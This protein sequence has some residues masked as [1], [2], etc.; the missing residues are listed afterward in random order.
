MKA[1]PL[2]ANPDCPSPYDWRS[3]LSFPQLERLH[4]ERK[5]R[6]QWTQCAQQA[7][8]RREWKKTSEFNNNLKKWNNEKFSRSDSLRRRPNTSR[9]P[10]KN[11]LKFENQN[12]QR[13]NYPP[14]RGT[15]SNPKK[16]VSSRKKNIIIGYSRVCSKH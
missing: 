3:R 10:K 7:A 5:A 15:R 1:T 16:A 9:D 13:K 4:M 6:K 12:L 11:L 2:P 8:A 14:L